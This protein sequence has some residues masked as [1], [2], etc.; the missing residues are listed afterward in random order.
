MINAYKI[1]IEN[2]EGTRTY[3]GPRTR[4]NDPIDFR[5][6]GCVVVDWIKLAVTRISWPV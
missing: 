2:P 6:T 4:W 5:E 3:G 1:E